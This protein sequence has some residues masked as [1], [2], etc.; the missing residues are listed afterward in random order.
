MADRADGG[1]DTVGGSS[2]GD[3]VDNAGGATTRGDVFDTANYD[4]SIQVD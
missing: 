3:G 4:P 2:G 1:K